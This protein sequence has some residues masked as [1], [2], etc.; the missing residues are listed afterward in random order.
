MLNGTTLISEGQQQNLAEH[1]GFS[2]MDSIWEILRTPKNDHFGDYWNY[3]S[4]Y[5]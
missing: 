5:D 4:Y 3:K 1:S 2:A